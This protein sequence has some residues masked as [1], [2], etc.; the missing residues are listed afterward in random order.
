MIMSLYG[1]DLAHVHDLGF[2]DYALGAAPG[3]LELLRRAGISDGISVDLGCGSGLLLRELERAGFDTVG[4][5]SSRSMIEAARKIAPAAHL[6]VSSAYDFGLSDDLPQCEAI[7]EVLSY[8]PPE[9]KNPPE[10]IDCFRRIAA[11]L[12]RG[13]LFIFGLVMSSGQGSFDYRSWRAGDGWAVLVNVAE[14]PERAQLTREITTFREQGATYRR[15]EERHVLRLSTRDDVVRDLRAA[16]FSVRVLRRYGD[17]ELP[18]RRL[19][20]RARKR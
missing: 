14:N 17:F 20:F 13:G 19:A 11:V 1:E 7:G 12:R 10:L 18:F 3:I 8:R 2:G 16:G 6:C 9:A 15:S 4:I 5:D